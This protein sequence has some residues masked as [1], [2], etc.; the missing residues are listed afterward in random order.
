[1]ERNNI[2][3]NLLLYIHTFVFLLT[4]KI[5]YFVTYTIPALKPF[6]RYWVLIL[7]IVTF[8][9]YVTNKGFKIP[10]D[11]FLICGVVWFVIVLTS[12]ILN[13][14]SVIKCIYE[15]AKILS[16]FILV[17]CYD[18]KNADMLLKI[19]SVI[20]TVYLLFNFIFFLIH[21]NGIRVYEGVK[22][23]YFGGQAYYFFDSVSE[24]PNYL[25]TCIATIIISRCF[26][27]QNVILKWIQNIIILCT[28]VMLLFINSSTSRVASILLVLMI[29]FHE[30]LFI[31]A[32][33]KRLTL[34]FLAV[35]LLL[36]VFNIREWLSFIIVDILGE[37][38]SMHGRAGIWEMARG[39][40]LDKP[41]LGYGY[42][43]DLYHNS[44]IYKVSAGWYTHSHCEFLEYLLHGGL[45]G[46]IPITIFSYKIIDNLEYYYKSQRLAQLLTITIFIFLLM[47]VNETCFTVYFFMIVAIVKNIDIFDENICCQE[48]EN[49]SLIF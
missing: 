18:S 26:G 43:S 19:A 41:I 5:P 35:L 16:F 14:G 13:S 46:M 36:V 47:S 24:S 17:A 1:M 4:I 25:L 30:K 28:L 38:L 44:V 9:I 29:V 42:L 11:S 10:I 7:L 32:S 34:V 39:A 22:Q 2:R 27:E 33:P 23:F 3:E 21:P 8:L 15:F 20:F 6:V 49:K 40:F 37:D 48:T 12:T 45:L 31:I